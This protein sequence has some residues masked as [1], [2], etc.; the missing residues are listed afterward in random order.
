MVPDTI[1][2]SAPAERKSQADNP[3]ARAVAGLPVTVRTKV[4]V[5]LAVFVV[6]V[7]AVAVLGLRVLGQSNARGASVRDLELRVA[8][9]QGLETQANQLR[10]LLALRVGQD[11]SLNTYLSGDASEVQGGRS[12]VLV[13]RT[14]AGTLSQLGP[15]TNASRFGF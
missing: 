11:P 4:L 8:T 1:A 2:G 14:I 15:A 7:I 10:Q 5:A 6:L 3:L 13:D 12:W 9:Y